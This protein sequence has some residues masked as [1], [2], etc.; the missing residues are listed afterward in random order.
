MKSHNRQDGSG[1]AIDFYKSKLATNP[2][3]ARYNTFMGA[4]YSSKGKFA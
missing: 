3:M 2:E 1:V 4:I